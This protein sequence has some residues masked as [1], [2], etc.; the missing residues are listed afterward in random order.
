MRRGEGQEA[1]L[2]VLG[3]DDPSQ[4]KG[5]GVTKGTG[6]RRTNGVEEE[7]KKDGRIQDRGECMGGEMRRGGTESGRIKVEL[8]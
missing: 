6:D 1:G 4:E 5:P 8:F 7:V 2:E 3:E